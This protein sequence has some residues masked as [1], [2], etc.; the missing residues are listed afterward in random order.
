MG[1]I[2]GGGGLGNIEHRTDG[3]KDRTHLTKAG[4]VEVGEQG[5]SG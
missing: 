3:W 1:Q 5:E 2:A 4:T